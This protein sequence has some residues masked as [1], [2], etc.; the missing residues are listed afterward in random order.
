MRILFWAALIIIKFY[1]MLWAHSLCRLL[2]HWDRIINI[3]TVFMPRFEGFF[4]ADNL[5]WMTAVM[6]VA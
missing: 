5:F 4:V 3:A 2:F 6:A 1:A